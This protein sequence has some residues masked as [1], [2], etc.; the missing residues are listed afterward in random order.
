M[1]LEGREG[2]LEEVKGDAEG[3]RVGFLLPEE[4]ALKGAG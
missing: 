2:L 3:F 4:L 1:V